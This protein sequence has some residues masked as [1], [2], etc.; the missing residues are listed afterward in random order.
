MG[1][2]VEDLN[3]KRCGH[4]LRQSLPANWS[5]TCAVVLV[6]Q[7]IHLQS[8][9]SPTAAQPRSCTKRSIDP[10]VYIDDIRVPIGVPNEFKARDIVAAGFESFLCWWCTKNKNTDGINYIYYNQQ[11]FI[12]YTVDALEGQAE[13]LQATSVMTGKTECPWT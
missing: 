3:G 5:G 7:E 10:S 6:A 11:R 1:H 8:V 9:E 13:Q 4:G 2:M 12:D